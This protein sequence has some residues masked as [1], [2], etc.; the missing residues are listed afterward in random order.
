MSFHEEFIRA[1][2]ERHRRLSLLDDEITTPEIKCDETDE[3][4]RGSRAA[5]GDDGAAEQ[6][7]APSPGPQ[8][9][10]EEA[11]GKATAKYAAAMAGGQTSKT[12]QVEVSNRSVHDR[13]K[14]TAETGA[15][16]GDDGGDE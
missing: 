10:V 9:N 6:V 3:Q 12:T 5:S 16:G 11:I 15:D 1:S 14:I 13:S 7:A 2:K 8:A 4:G